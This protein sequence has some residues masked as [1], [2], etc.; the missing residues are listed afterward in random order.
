MNT[1]TNTLVRPTESAATSCTPRAHP[2]RAAPPRRPAIDS[3]TSIRGLAALWVVLYHFQSDIVAL[4]PFT[5]SLLPFLAQGHFAVPIFFVLSGYVLTYNYVESIGARPQLSDVF[6]FWGRRLQ[7]IYPLHL[8]T[9]LAV[10]PMV[11]V[12]RSR[13]LTISETGY[14]LRDFVL[15]LFLLQTWVPH[16]QLN[17]N[18]PSWSVSS[19]WFAYLFFPLACLVFIRVRRRA[20]LAAL[21]LLLYALS[22]GR[23]FAGDLPFGAMT[24][25]VGPFLLG[26]T[27]ARAVALGHIPPFGSRIGAW[28]FLSALVLSPYFAADQALAIAMMTAGIALVF[29]LAAT[30][31]SCARFWLWRPLIVLGDVSYSLYMVH[32][33]VQK[34]VNEIAPAAKFADRSLAVRLLVLAG[35]ATAIALATWFAHVWIDLYF[36]RS[37]RRRFSA[38][39][40]L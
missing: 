9:L 4:L 6:R 18:Y 3:L 5:R 26:C 27:F 25:V 32:T 33:L 1:S 29:A 12:A 15:N 21:A 35:Y 17:W 30:G 2:Y 8:A 37:L 22:I 7:R 14:S 28:L 36:R 23:M 11:L 38:V 19:E 40:S 31:E 10:V 13:G 16:F 39:G 20:S 24:A 34:L